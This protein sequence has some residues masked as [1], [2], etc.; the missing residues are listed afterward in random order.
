LIRGLADVSSIGDV[1][2]L[3]YLFLQALTQ[4]KEMPSLARLHALRRVHLENMKGLT[5]LGP[6]AKAPALED[7]EVFNLRHLDPDA[8]KPFVGHRTLR[9]ASVYLSNQRKNEAVAELLGLPPVDGEFRFKNGKGDV[10]TS[11]R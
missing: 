10:Q 7:L 2:S 3:Q 1:R 11:R 8:L 6:V 9:R 5:R 4:V